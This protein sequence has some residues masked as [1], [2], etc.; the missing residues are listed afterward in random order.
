MYKNT[1]DEK[2]EELDSSR[3]GLS[4]QER[5]QRR[6]EYGYNEVLNYEKRSVFSFFAETFSLTIQRLLIL[7]LAFFAYLGRFNEVGLFLVVFVFRALVLTIKP[8]L[9]QK[10][11]IKF[12]EE[13]VNKCKVIEE[14]QLVEIPIRELVPG[15]V[16]QLNKGDLIPADGRLIEGDDIWI[17]ESLLT[18]NKEPFCK[19]VNFISE[20]QVP[21]GERANM[22]YASTL[23]CQGY[24]LMLVTATGMHTEIGKVAFMLY[25]D[26]ARKSL[27]E[28]K[29]KSQGKIINALILII[30][31]AIGI[32]GYYRGLNMLE[33]VF[34]VIS[35]STAASLGGF[36]S[37]IYDVESLGVLR[38]SKRGLLLKDISTSEDLAGI[39]V[40]IFDETPFISKGGLKVRDLSSTSEEDE[41]L[42]KKISVLSARDGGDEWREHFIP[43]R[44]F[45]LGENPSLDIEVEG[46]E[47]L[48]NYESDNLYKSSYK[49]PEGIFSFALGG[50]SEIIALSSKYSDGEELL[51]L[52]DEVK[53]G[54]FTMEEQFVSEG[55]SVVA[56]AYRLDEVEHERDFIFLGLI[57]LADGGAKGAKEAIKTMK[58]AGIVPILISNSTIEN[59]SQLARETGI[60]VPGFE[61]MT[62]EIMDEMTDEEFYT[63]FEDYRVYFNLKDNHRARLVDAWSS[64]GHR[65]AISLTYMDHIS[66]S[67]EA[68]IVL[69]SKEDSLPVVRQ[70]ADV[71]MLRD[72][73]SS[74]NDAVAEARMIYLNARRRVR[75]ELVVA[76]ALILSS[77]AVM[78][79]YDRLILSFM[80]YIWLGLVIKLLIGLTLEKEPMERNVLYQG[81]PSI[82]K[83]LIQRRSAVFSIFE[84][85]IMA[86][87]VFVAFVLLQPNKGLESPSLAYLTF[88][89]G[90]IFTAFNLRN[91]QSILG[92]GFFSNKSFFLYSV[93]SIVLILLPVSFEFLASTYSMTTLSPQY[94]G[95]ALGLAFIPVIITELR[96]IF[97]KE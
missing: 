58:T 3:Q 46:Y 10:A 66:S 31:L 17:D 14:G 13:S 62:A 5:A 43:Y 68:S 83:G 42:M 41:L 85:L 84:G 57:A 79:V 35:L 15:D 19:D 45:A 73:L 11:R 70:Q 22:I 89:F 48:R 34:V 24:G 39:S 8:Y 49:T 25:K 92:K 56:M 6:Q 9:V 27:L 93:L 32:Y 21:L 18:G 95:L 72:D 71:L 67:K 20:G 96:K 12:H 28:D 75:Y 94:Y 36:K 33:L 77:L 59:G 65:V 97:I 29:L 61:I 50:L 38:Y 26:N 88:G 1:I 37:L 30:S 47:W 16:V 7:A 64:R 60:L 90:L 91:S 78:L 80:A 54:I 74:F 55:K 4:A 44:D 81:P 53:Q 87:V 40:A 51:E 2:L 23:V 76:L 52:N 63:V 69:A 86:V 82:D